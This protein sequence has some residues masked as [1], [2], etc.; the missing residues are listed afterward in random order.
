MN[1][2][3]TVRFYEE[4]ND[5]LRKD[6]RKRDIDFSFDGRRSVKDLIESFGVP[7]VE[8]DLVLVNGESVGFDYI[9]ADGDRHDGD[10][11]I[12]SHG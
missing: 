11:G 8:V 6:R 9:V 4:L 5:F 2:R 7:H 1:Y 12:G 10:P 3:V